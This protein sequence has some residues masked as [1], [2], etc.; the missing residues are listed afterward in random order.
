MELKNYLSDING[1]DKLY[2]VVNKKLLDILNLSYSE[3]KSTI[4]SKKFLFD[5]GY[6]KSTF[7]Q[8]MRGESFPSL[9]LIKLMEKFSNLELLDS[10]YK[11]VDYM[12]GKTN[13]T[14]IKIPKSLSKEFVYLF[15]ALRDGSLVHYSHV[16]EIEFAQ[17]YREWLDDSIVPRMRKIFDVEP[18]VKNRKNGTY[19]IR[20]RSIVLFMILNH[21]TNFFKEKYKHTPEVILGLPFELQK[22][23]IAGFYDA[24]GNKNPKDIT[25]YQQWWNKENCPP[26][27]DIQLMLRKV[28]IESYF[29][30]KPQNDA[31]LFDLHVE[32]KSRK[33]FLEI[34]PI[35]H[36]V[37]HRCLVNSKL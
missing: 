29:R 9:K 19:I 5:I 18:N 27:A 23:Y 12:R 7:T 32:G 20:K 31:F 22:F 21:F 34:I 36:P 3:I 10:V 11:C 16:Y 2:L 1:D 8:I 14:T 26:L 4:G 37:I 35:E 17:K 6:S 28:G 33:R 30:I 15:G 25:F 13:S 24:E